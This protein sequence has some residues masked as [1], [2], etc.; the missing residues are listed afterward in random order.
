MPDF[1]LSSKMAAFNPIMRGFCD[2]IQ[3]LFA[4]RVYRRRRDGDWTTVFP[5]GD[6]AVTSGLPAGRQGREL[7]AMSARNPPLTRLSRLSM[8]CRL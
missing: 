4:K 8:G 6:T 3:M 5:G 1:K 2:A 7:R